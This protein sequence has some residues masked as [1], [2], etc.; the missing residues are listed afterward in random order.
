MMALCCMW[1]YAVQQHIALCAGRTR[2][3]RSGRGRVPHTW[4]VIIRPQPFGPAQ[5]YT[6]AVKPLQDTIVPVRAGRTRSCPSGPA[7]VPGRVPR[8]FTQRL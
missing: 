6:Q 5:V 2:S 8:E 4:V 7:I 1:G 3:C